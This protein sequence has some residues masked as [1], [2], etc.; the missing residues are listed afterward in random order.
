MS[1]LQDAIGWINR[2]GG[3]KNAD[4]RKG[5]GFSAAT[6]YKAKAI[7]REE[8]ESAY[9][10]PDPKE[11]TKAE[12]NPTKDPFVHMILEMEKSLGLVELH[13]ASGELEVV[14]RRRIKVH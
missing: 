5:A 14:Q 1:K 10:P 4:F 6:F 9:H 12:P 3:Y 7:L 13:Y 2:R 11:E 8:D